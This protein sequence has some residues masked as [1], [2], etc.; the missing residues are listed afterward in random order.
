[1]IMQERDSGHMGI[2]WE[3]QIKTVSHALGSVLAQSSQRLGYA[4]LRTLFYEAM[5]IVN[6]HPL[7]VDNISDD[8]GPES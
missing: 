2:V 7:T 1:M 5:S 8:T 4:S 3:Q 6:S